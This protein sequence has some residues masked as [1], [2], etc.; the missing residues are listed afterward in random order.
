MRR[1]SNPLDHVR[2]AAPCSADWE[3]MVGNDRVRFCG[4]CNL[5][6]YNLSHLSR[7]EA[8]SLISSSEGRLCARFYRRADGSILTKNCPVGLRAIRRRLSRVAQAISAA[9]ISF[10][11]GV[12]VYT[13][14]KPVLYK[15]QPRMGVIARPPQIG[16]PAESPPPDRFEAGRLTRIPLR[17][18]AIDRG[19]AHQRS[20][21]RR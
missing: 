20:S 18:I 17:E 7:R 6:V 21:R 1:F 2:I 4:Q 15:S 10:F 3:Q 16:Q 19:K 8:E 5:N 12:G 14:S 11:A 13:F 9:L